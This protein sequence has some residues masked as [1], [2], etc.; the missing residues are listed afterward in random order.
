MDH[1]I[2]TALIRLNYLGDLGMSEMIGLMRLHV[3]E[4]TR[5]TSIISSGTIFKKRQKLQLISD[6]REYDL[7]HTLFMDETPNSAN[8]NFVGVYLAT[9]CAKV[10]DIGKPFFR[11]MYSQERALKPDEYQ[12]QKAHANLSRLIIRSWSNNCNILCN[13]EGLVRFIADAASAHHEKVDGTGYPDGKGGESISLFGRLLAITDVISALMNER[14]Y[15]KP[16]PL[17]KCMDIINR[18]KGTHFDPDLVNSVTALYNL[19]AFTEERVLG[20][21]IEKEK[22]SH[23]YAGFVRSIDFEKDIV[24][25]GDREKLSELKEIIQNALERNETKRGIIDE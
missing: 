22:F 25:K 20:K 24:H 17:T 1:E 11:E 9:I 13:H 21:W 5:Y 14:P 7:D 4:I 12:K 10:H 8:L 19:G 2:Y 6:F 15:S 3:Q 23:E 16:V 18:N